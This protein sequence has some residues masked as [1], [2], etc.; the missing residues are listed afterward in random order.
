MATHTIYTLRSPCSH[1]ALSYIDSTTGSLPD[2]LKEH[3]SNP[4]AKVAEM[5][6]IQVGEMTIA[7]L[8]TVVGNEKRVQTAV[9]FYSLY[10]KHKHRAQLPPFWVRNSG[11]CDGDMYTAHGHTWATIDRIKEAYGV[12]G[13][14]EPTDDAIDFI[15]G[16]AQVKTC[17]VCGFVCDHRNIARH[18]KSSTCVPGKQPTKEEKTTL[19]KARQNEKV[20]CELCGFVTM[21]R[22]LPRHQEGSRCKKRAKMKVE[23]EAQDACV[24]CEIE[25]EE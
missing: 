10:L 20:A 19:A 5:L 23:A 7:P 22:N 8:Y 6:E 24:E 4:N 2:A 17:G 18:R 12:N 13:Y 3:T 25:S 1:G 15:M 16:K 9:D 21:A 11:Y 14:T